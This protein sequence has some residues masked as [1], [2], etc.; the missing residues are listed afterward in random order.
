[1]T[2]NASPSFSILVYSTG[3]LDSK[4]QLEAG[5]FSPSNAWDHIAR[6]GGKVGA[7]IERTCTRLKT[8]EAQATYDYI[9]DIMQYRN[10]LRSERFSTF[11]QAYARM[12]ELAP[13]NFQVLREA[14][15]RANG[16]AILPGEAG[17]EDRSR[18]AKKP[19]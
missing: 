17:D 19:A 4:P 13:G 18:F 8:E 5:Y 10:A 3:L 1:M 11:E 9:L 12:E 7:N 6:M 16:S 2:A 14:P 15:K